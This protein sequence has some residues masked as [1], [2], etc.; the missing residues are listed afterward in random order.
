MLIY[1]C[2]ATLDI[3]VFFC[4]PLSKERLSW[5]LSQ[6]VCLAE[7]LMPRCHDEDD[8]ELFLGMKVVVVDLL[9][10]F[11]YSS[12]MC[13]NKEETKQHPGD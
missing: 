2:S 1:S 9:F 6:K 12:T 13:E 10:T 11:S 5:E 8:P 4:I 3:G 7:V